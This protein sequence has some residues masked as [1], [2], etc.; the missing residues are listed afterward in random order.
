MKECEQEINR[1]KHLIDEN[2]RT[3]KHDDMTKGEVARSLADELTNVRDTLHSFVL[4]F[5][6]ILPLIIAIL[7]M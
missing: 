7:Y 3:L 6:H 4:S 2:C 5:L 1:L